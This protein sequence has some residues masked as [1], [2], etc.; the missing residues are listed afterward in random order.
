MRTM[1]KQYFP[2]IREDQARF[3]VDQI[4][5]NKT[6]IQLGIFH[7]LDQTLIGVIS[8]G[9]IDFI[10]RKCEIGGLIG[11]T[12][13]KNIQYWLEANR[14][15]ILHARDRLNM[16]R[17]YGASISKELAVFY[18]RLLGFEL[19]GVLRHEVYKDG[20]FHDAYR[21]ALIFGPKT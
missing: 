1:Q 18:Q 13:Y 4:Q 21:F 6:L 3:F 10:N 19:E 11:E 7:K 14:L 12:K 8:L 15:I 5:G 2:N 16:H 20:E 17:I 9:A